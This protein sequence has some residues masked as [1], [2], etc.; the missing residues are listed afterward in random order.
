[1]TSTKT[2]LRVCIVREVPHPHQTP[3]TRTRELI[4]HNFNQLN[5][6]IGGVALI[7]ALLLFSCNV[8]SNSIW[9]LVTHTIFV[10]LII[11]MSCTS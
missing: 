1:M 4:N 9:V 2:Y 6:L 11:S 3:L 7:G 5:Y 8:T 10:L